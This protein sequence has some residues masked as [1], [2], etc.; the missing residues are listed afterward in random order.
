MTKEQLK[1]LIKINKMETKCFIDSNR[2]YEIPDTC[3]VYKD[4]MFYYL[5]IVSENGCVD[6][7]RKSKQPETFYDFCAN[8]LGINTY[9]EKTP[10]L[11]K[12]NN[13]GRTNKRH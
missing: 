13:H 8:F 9:R 6:I 5:Y 10:V 4:G 11:K 1:E 12:G 7:L 3:G 2:F